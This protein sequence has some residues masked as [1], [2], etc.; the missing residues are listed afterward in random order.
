MDIL[1]DDG[2]HIDYQ[3]AVTLFENIDNI[4][5]DGLIVIEDTHSSYMKEFGNPNKFSLLT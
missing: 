2:G 5:D 4:N 3:Q 1:L